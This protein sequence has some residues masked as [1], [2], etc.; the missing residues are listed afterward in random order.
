MTSS[1]TCRSFC[2][3]FLPTGK[4]KLASGAF[5]KSRSTN[6]PIVIIF[7]LFT[8]A[9]APALALAPTFFRGM[10][11]NINLEKATKWVLKLFVKS[12]KHD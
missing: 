2:R 6:T 1:R 5:T 10:Y 4:N 12:Q 8:L 7:Y 3:N 9:L 11:T